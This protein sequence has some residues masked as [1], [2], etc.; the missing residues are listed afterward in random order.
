MQKCLSLVLGFENSIFVLSFLIVA[1]LKKNVVMIGLGVWI[2]TKHVRIYWNI[3][4]FYLLHFQR[5]Q[6]LL[7]LWFIRIQ[8]LLSF[9]LSKTSMTS[10]LWFMRIQ[11]LLSFT[12]S[13]TSMSSVFYAFKDFNVFCLLRFQRLQCLLSLW[14]IRL[15]CLLF[16]TLSKTSM[17]SALWFIRLQCLLIYDFSKTSTSSALSFIGLN[18]LVFIFHR[19]QYPCL[20]VS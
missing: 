2:S 6:C 14:F 18:V 11:C 1:F 5:L 3:N 12:L 9:M 19:T 20:C 7:S 13:K 17:S 8:Y 16:F 10:A 4:V 15:Q